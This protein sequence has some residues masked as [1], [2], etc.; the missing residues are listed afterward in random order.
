MKE[1]FSGELVS[2]AEKVIDVCTP[3]A[4]E[5]NL[6]YYPLQSR[7]KNKPKFLFI[8]L[9]PGGGY[10]YNC[11]KNNP[12]WEFDCDKSRLTAQRLLLGNPAF[13]NGFN[14]GKW[15]YG[16]GLSKIPF[17]R[18]SIKNYDFVFA[19]YIF[20]SS[21]NYS[22]I[23]KKELQN[24]I[25][26]NISLTKELIEIIE[27]QYIIVLGTSSGIDKISENNKLFLQ[28]YRKRLLVKG[29]IGNIP[30]FGIPHPSYNNFPNENEAISDMLHKL[31]NDQE[32]EPLFLPQIPNHRS[33]SR[34]SKTMFHLEKFR[35]YYKE[36]ITSENEKWLDIII[37]GIDSDR[38]LIR[39]NPHNKD[40]GIRKEGKKDFKE[41]KHSSF[42]EKQ[43]DQTYDRNHSSWLIRKSFKDFCCV[44]SDLIKDL[45]NFLEQVNIEK[46]KKH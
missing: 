45:D 6:E 35:N 4:E 39:I 20:Y 22:E 30:A 12:A 18:E 42:Y 36:L 46:T 29:K 44:D 10:G 7:V 9:N 26:D 23:K 27:P 32:V 43:F 11:Q 34:D 24:S 28:G 3:V 25:A 37:D 8:G 21:K 17:L 14:S 1:E 38:I 40:F 16:N 15:K 5:F 31:I 13:E 33:K 19:N 2:W 41:L